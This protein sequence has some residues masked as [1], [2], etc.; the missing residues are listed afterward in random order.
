M[1]H[2]ISDVIYPPVSEDI[3]AKLA[4]DGRFGTLLTAVEMAGLGELLTESKQTPAQSLKTIQKVS[5]YE[6]EMLIP[7]RLSRVIFKQCEQST[8]FL[9][10]L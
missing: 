2:F 10:W 7:M 9:A 8:S 3:P 6:K 1:I 5:F 4:S